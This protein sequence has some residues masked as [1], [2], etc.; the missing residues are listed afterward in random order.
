MPRRLA[1]ALLALLPGCA[2]RHPTTLTVAVAASL[3]TAMAEV[4]RGY[5]GGR[6][7]FNFGASGALARQIANGAPVDVFLSAAPK[8]M[9]ELAAQGLILSDT[10]RDLLRN[11]IVL[12]AS[13]P[14]ASFDDLAGPQ[15]KLIALGDPESVPAGDEGR[16]GGTTRGVSEWDS[17][18]GGGGG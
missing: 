13:G 10:R 7:D 1:S 8:P 2:Q 17:G 12:V 11:E 4:V 18:G 15:V 9:D 5:Q 3:Q 6:V 16:E 14:V